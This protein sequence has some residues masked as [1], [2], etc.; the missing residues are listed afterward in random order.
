MLR[1]KKFDIQ[2]L[3]LKLSQNVHLGIPDRG[4]VSQTR[5]RCNEFHPRISSN[6]I[7]LNFIAV[8]G[9]DARPSDRLSGLVERAAAFDVPGP[10]EMRLESRLD[11]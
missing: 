3:F 8:S 6:F 7:E 9:Q 10:R 1:Y 11:S 4:I 2:P 5:R